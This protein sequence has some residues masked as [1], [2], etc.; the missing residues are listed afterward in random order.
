MRIAI[1]IQ[2]MQTESRFR[3]IGRYIG[4]LLDAFAA[5]NTDH[6]VFLLVNANF[7]ES[8]MELR[9]RYSQPRSNFQVLQW[10]AFDQATCES[11][12]SDAES[13]VSRSLFL[14]FVN[15]LNPDVFLC[16]SI[17]EGYLNAANTAI[18]KK[19]HRSYIY[20]AIV[21]DL[22]PFR[23]ADIYL[24]D[25][26]YAAFYQKKLA[27]I[28]NVDIC[29]TISE[30]SK[31]DIEE[32][33]LIGGGTAVNISAGRDA[34][35]QPI[36]LEEEH[37]R[38]LL[39][40]FS[41]TKP[42]LLYVGGSD[43]RKNLPRLI[44]AFA[45]I[46]TESLSTFQLAIVGKIPNAD[47]LGQIASDAG[48]NDDNLRLLSHV[49]DNE[50]SQLYNSSRAVIA[51]SLYE[52]FGLTVLEAMACGTPV[53]CSNTTSLK[54]VVDNPIATF[55]PLSID[56]MA[57]RISQVLNDQRYRA[58]LIKA[59]LERANSYTWELS[60][61]RLMS[62][63][64]AAYP[65]ENEVSVTAARKTFQETIN[66]LATEIT[67][68]PDVKNWNRRTLVPIA[69]AVEQN[70]PFNSRR[71]TLFVDVSELAQR[72][73][74]TGVQRVARSLLVELIKSPPMGYIVKPVYATVDVEGY[75]YAHQ[76]GNRL[77]GDHFY[78][79]ID[80]PIEYN[81][82]DI[83]FG[84]DLQHHVVA[85]QADYLRS[86]QEK[87]VQI[88]FVIYDLLPI[89][90][91][92]FWDPQANVS[93][94][95][96]DWLNLA[97]S[98][99]SV[100]CI[101]STV[102][103]ELRRWLASS[104]H[105]N[106]K[107]LNVQSFHL[108]SD[109]ELSVTTK[110][111]PKNSKAVLSRLRDAPSFL[112]VGTV[113]PRKAHASVLDAAEQLWEEGKIFNLMI[114]GSRGWLVDELLERIDK[115][116]LLNKHLFLLDDVSDEYLSKIYDHSDC[117][118]AAS[119]GE[120][121]GLPLIEAAKRGLPI[122]CRDI[123]V[124]REVAKEF[125]LYFGSETTESLDAAM[126][127]WLRSYAN[128]SHPRSHGLQWL[129]WEQSARSVKTLLLEHETPRKQLLIDIS[130]LVKHDAKTGIQRVVRNILWELLINPPAGYRVA[131]V[132]ASDE[133]P[134]RYAS[135]Y[136]RSIL[137]QAGQ[138]DVDE[139][140]NY[141]S[142]DIFLGLDLQPQ[143][144]T[145]HRDFY[146]KLRR[147]GVKVHFIVYDLLPILS[148]HYFPE[149]ASEGF[150]PWLETVVEN[151]SPI[152][153]SRA[154]AAELEDWTMRMKS[155]QCEK[156]TPKYFSLGAD[157]VGR[158]FYKSAKFQHDFVTER[159][160]NKPRFLMV[161]TLEPRKGHTQ[162]LNAFDLL[163]ADGVDVDL[164]VVGKKGWMA[165]SLC[166]RLLD[167]PEAG[168][169]LFWLDGIS[170]ADLN[171]T[172]GISSCLIAASNGEGFGLPLIEAAQKGLPIIARDLPVFREVAHEGAYFFKG[173]TPQ[174]LQAAIHRWLELYRQGS[175]PKSDAIKCVSWSE[176]ALSL[177]SQMNLQS[178]L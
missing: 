98:F 145:K 61:A 46:G 76:Y 141:A 133:L 80:S 44:H 93:K 37:S 120:G 35:F 67:Q 39:A 166:Q 51:P 40:L 156:S 162:A 2:G 81:E 135:N 104:D 16:S 78:P 55:D 139:Y 83:F 127:Y 13:A 138:P 91:P 154:V 147:Q 169:H 102:A 24:Q 57:V 132:Y 27:E 142:G 65:I 97:C 54:E 118:L 89:Q 52:G 124:F 151:D 71:R 64:E 23:M 22:I 12:H 60:A 157:F 119:Y 10:H 109:F 148:P 77:F 32:S 106:A 1:D 126:R 47:E 125:A 53:I 121:F 36:R 8:V 110:G 33:K 6:E 88:W 17:F 62:A 136:S 84:L 87:G 117:L 56:D 178:A 114:V 92:E 173:D 123:P 45:A 134:Y 129:S 31:T 58:K 9:S 38:Q 94:M 43:A 103:D 49:T 159:M 150:V 160:V 155:D 82:S 171:N 101:S 5:I 112:M 29:L 177:I 176:S 105:P 75:Q 108:G 90:F 66:T 74:G 85:A 68:I 59:G 69:E 26:N 167:H 146:Q 20:V 15:N 34:C 14:S 122:I 107:N 128:D 95:H 130:E 164:I 4:S 48:L 42:Y 3:G 161:G 174:D 158:E 175:H 50:L 63:L 163:W 137:Q 140:I 144:V 18:P 25:E 152:C 21:Y 172:Y 170:D 72:D 28:E 41:I 131:A 143:V 149:G 100:L 153:I 115:N 7:P 19:E 111:I 168:E 30:F 116:P 165:D 96:E 70:H 11:V 73:S 113:E 79:Q 99:S 86:M